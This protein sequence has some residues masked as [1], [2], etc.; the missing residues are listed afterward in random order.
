[1]IVVVDDENRK[2]E[3]DLT[4]AVEMVPPEAINFRATYGKDLICLAMTGENLERLNLSPWCR[5]AMLSVAERLLSVDWLEDRAL[6]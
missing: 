4:L 1:M 6:S 3:G 2:N 5:I